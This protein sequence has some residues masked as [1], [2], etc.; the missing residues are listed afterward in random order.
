M[1]YYDWT[2]II[3]EKTNSELKAII[4][5][6]TLSHEAIRMA[7]N[8]L[9]HRNDPIFIKRFE[10]IKNL[11]SDWLVMPRLVFQGKCDHCRKDSKFL[12]TVERN[13]HV[14]VSPFYIKIM[15]VTF[16]LTLREIMSFLGLGKKQEGK[17]GACMACGKIMIQC[18]N[19]NNMQTLKEDCQICTKCD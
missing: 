3:S 9:K 4:R 16:L 17:T 7:E 1:G 15:G 18:K 13:P 10:E 2:K 11:H 6:R 8:E 14:K 12:L 19:C 5:D